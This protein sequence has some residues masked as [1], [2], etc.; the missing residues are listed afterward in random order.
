MAPAHQRLA[1]GDRVGLQVEAGL[2]VDLE[3]AVDERL[4]QVHFQA[5]AGADLG[6]HVGFEE[7]IGAAAG[8]LG[9]VHRQIRVLQDLV[10]IGA[11]LRRQRDADTG[12]GGHLMAETLVGRADRSED[13][14]DQLHH[15]VDI[16]DPGLNDGKLVAAEPGHE[17]GFARAGDEARRDRFQKL[18]ADHVAE[19]VVDALEFVDVDIKYGQLPVRRGVGQFALEPFV[20]Q[21]AVRQICQRVEMGEVG[22]ALLGAAPLGNVFVRRQPSAVRHRLVDDL[23][24]ASVGRRDDHG[25][26][27]GDV[28]RHHLDVMVDVADERTG[29]LA[30]GDHLAKAATRLHDFGREAVHL[31][32]PLVADD[33]M[34]LGIEQQEA[35]RHVV[36]GGV[37][38]L[39]LQ[40]QPLPGRA[41]LVRKLADDKQQ[42]GGDRQ[43][44][45]SG[46]CDQDS[47]LL[48]PVGQCGRRRGRS[49]DHDRKI[50]QR[51][52]RDQPVLAVDRAGETRRAA[53][54][55]EY[56]PLGSRTGLE[57]LADHISH[58]R[59]T[60]EQ[61][62]VAVVH[63]DGGVGSERY[64][65]EEF[66]EV[67]GFDAAADDAEEFAFRPGDLARDHRGPGAGDAAVDRL[68]QHLR[69]LRAGLEGPEI[70]AVRHVDGGQRPAGRCIDQIAFGVEDVD[71]TDI[72][73]RLDLGFQ[74]QMDVMAGH[75]ALV[76]FRGRD[77]IGTHERDQV[78]LHDLE[79]FELLV[80]MAGEQQHGVFQLAF[81]AAQRALAEIA[82]HDGRADGDGGDQERAA[83]DQPADRA[84]AEGGRNP[85]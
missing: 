53:G 14:A 59:I 75:P 23:D 64:G 79:V 8:G 43:H 17:V 28:A 60:G 80:E 69:R 5:A 37:E 36:D 9:R 20:E 52:R 85:E 82:G 56:L 4:A 16:L 24:R 35:L 27:M 78:L 2:V 67:D 6:L 62:A 83:Q 33:E 51:A 57:V 44:G 66:F 49:D 26:T 58:M 29:I 84:A 34:L 11:V 55:L 1:A 74:H 42:Q 81:A 45:K 12:V 46:D 18:V 54:S 7:A 21:R 65:C 50:R 39:L 15:V 13:A 30:V 72:G 19:R 70:R 76:V 68:D 61:R 63:G 22:D 47:D 32:I 48:A 38:A 25:V 71:A 77:P 73:Q 41:V 3:A 31:E 10:D 40:R